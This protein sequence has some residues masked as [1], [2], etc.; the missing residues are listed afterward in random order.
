M[1]HASDPSVPQ[2]T[3][4]ARAFVWMSLCMSSDVLT[5]FL[6]CAETLAR[7]ARNAQRASSGLGA[8]GRMVAE[9]GI[10]GPTRNACGPNPPPGGTTYIFQWLT[11]KSLHAT[12]VPKA[13]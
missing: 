7:R 1:R 6:L 3:R 4:R 10:A 8:F 13:M 12:C 5:S 11:T 9:E 2:R